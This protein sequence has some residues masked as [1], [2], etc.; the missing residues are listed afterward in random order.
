LCT[1][2]EGPDPSNQLGERERLG[3]VIVGA[4]AEAHDAILDSR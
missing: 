2:R 1:A 3:K 4:E